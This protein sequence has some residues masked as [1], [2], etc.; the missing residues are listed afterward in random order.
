MT[1]QE[2]EQLTDLKQEIEELEKNIAKI[3]QM[4]IK[5]VSIKVSASSK[6]FPYVQSRT[7]VQEYDPALADKRD[8][9]LCEKRMLLCD[10]KEQAAEEERRLIQYINNI[11]ESR[12]RRIMQYRYVDGYSWEKIGDIM[13]FDRRTGERIVSR[14]LKRN[15]K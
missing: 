1:K 8:R 3:K 6:S 7:T 11:K 5:E 10:R 15:K 12:V 9:L 14:Y 13:H 4:D 2:L